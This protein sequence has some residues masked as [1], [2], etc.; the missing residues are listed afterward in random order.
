MRKRLLR[1]QNLLHLRK[2]LSSSLTEF[3]FEHFRKYW[4]REQHIMCVLV[5]TLLILILSHY[6]CVWPVPN[7]IVLLYFSQKIKAGWLFPFLTPDFQSYNII[8]NAERA[9]TFISSPPCTFLRRKCVWL[10]WWMVNEGGVAGLQSSS[11]ASDVPVAAVTLAVTRLFELS[12]QLRWQEGR[13]PQ[14]SLTQ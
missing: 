1:L 2:K 12:L 13:L 11:A 5:Q 14:S 4:K 9:E 3:L 6:A 7:W 8:S 10:L